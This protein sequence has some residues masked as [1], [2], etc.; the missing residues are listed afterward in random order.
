MPRSQLVNYKYAKP[1]VDVWATAATLYRMLTGST[2]RDFPP[3]IDPV[4][5]LLQ[6]SAV[7]V[8]QRNPSVPRRLAQVVDEAL[9]DHPRIVTT[10]ADACRQALRKAI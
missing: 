1:E 8:R 4:V 9:I 3:S 5:V 2:P 6:Q 7:P 10:T